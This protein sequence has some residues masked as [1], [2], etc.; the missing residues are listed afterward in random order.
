MFSLKN[1]QQDCLEMK[2]VSLKDEFAILQCYSNL[3]SPHFVIAKGNLFYAMI[4][5]FYK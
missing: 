3:E 5:C 1:L 2:V 4:L